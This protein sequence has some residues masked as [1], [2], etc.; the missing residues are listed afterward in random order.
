MATSSSPGASGPV[1]PDPERRF[2]IRVTLPPGDPFA[3]LL[4]A[5]WEAWHW[6][7]DRASRDA[8][9]QDMARR[10]VYSRIGDDPQIVLEAVDR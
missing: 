4:G 9:M 10:H 8:A 5:D 3:N 2:G 7:A 1:P 6:F